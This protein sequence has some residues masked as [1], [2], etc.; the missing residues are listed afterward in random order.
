MDLVP[1]KLVYMPG[2]QVQLQVVLTN[3]S[4]GKVELVVVSSLPPIISLV[5]AGVFVG[6]ALPPNV[7]RRVIGKPVKV[8]PSGNEERKLVVGEKV[9]YDLAQIYHP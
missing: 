8:F 7:D 9:T 5:P 3:A 1:S 2:E 6:P 4:K